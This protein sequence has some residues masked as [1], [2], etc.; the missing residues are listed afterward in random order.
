VQRLEQ[1]ARQDR[2]F[3][4]QQLSRLAFGVAANF[5]VAAQDG[6]W[7]ADPVAYSRGATAAIRELIRR[8]PGTADDPDRQ[9]AVQAIISQLLATLAQEIGR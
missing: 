7:G 5:A 3:G 6:D 8:V 1:S 9:L 4:D 2:Q